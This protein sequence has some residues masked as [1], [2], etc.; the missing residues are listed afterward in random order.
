MSRV[1]AGSALAMLARK[2]RDAG[3][4]NFMVLKEE[5]RVVS[6]LPKESWGCGDEE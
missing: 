6:N 2:R 3:M 1:S 5:G 4:E